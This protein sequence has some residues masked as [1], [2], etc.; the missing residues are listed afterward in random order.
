MSSVPTGWTNQKNQV[1]ILQ[2]LQHYTLSSDFHS[3]KVHSSDSQSPV[4]VRYTFRIYCHRG[5]WLW[6]A[7]VMPQS[8]RIFW[9]VASP[10]VESNVSSQCLRC[11]NAF[12]SS[13]VHWQYQVPDV[14]LEEPV[15]KSW[16]NMEIWV[17][18][19]NGWS[20]FNATEFIGSAMTRCI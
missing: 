8:P 18:L 4:S 6:V 1:E 13:I 11:Q 10:W 17:Q 15:I 20:D 7:T 19:S 9:Q 14:H 16:M 2:K 5:W 12:R 3:N